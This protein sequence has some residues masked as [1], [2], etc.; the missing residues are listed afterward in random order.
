MP[1][2][3]GRRVGPSTDGLQ[4]QCAGPCKQVNCMTG[5]H[6]GADQIVDS[7]SDSLFHRPGDRISVRAKCLKRELTAAH[8]TTNNPYLTRLIGNRRRCHG[9]M[10]VR[11]S[12][13]LFCHGIRNDGMGKTGR[14]LQSGEIAV[15]YPAILCQIDPHHPGGVLEVLFGLV[16]DGL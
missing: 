10:A 12:T 14:H 2:D 15:Q 1:F 16:A 8:P 13:L 9:T 7:L 4:A 11:R 3:E 6:L 5:C